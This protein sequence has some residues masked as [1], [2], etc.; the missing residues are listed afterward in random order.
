MLSSNANINQQSILREEAETSD[1]DAGS[2]WI[3][4]WSSGVWSRGVEAESCWSV[5]VRVVLLV[6]DD[7]IPGEA[8]VVV[9]LVSPSIAIIET[10]LEQEIVQIFQTK[11]FHTWRM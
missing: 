8:R 11:L 6:Q 1:L 9:P 3:V 4:S 5:H 2:A 10:I 7:L